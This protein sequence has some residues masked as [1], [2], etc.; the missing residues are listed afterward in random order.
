M[1]DI[2]LELKHSYV[3]QNEAEIK[4]FVDT[5]PFLYDCLQRVHNALQNYFP[6]ETFALE[7]TCDPEENT[8]TLLLSIQ[9]LRNADETMLL[10]ER[11]VDEWWLD[12]LDVGQGKITLGLSFQEV[13]NLPV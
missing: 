6:D 1:S 12:H 3:L 13:I 7:I 10:W 11:F 8:Q 9:T 5:N 4:V 2:T